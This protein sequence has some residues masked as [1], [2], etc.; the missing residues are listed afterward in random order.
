MAG[1]RV[2]TINRSNYHSTRPQIETAAKVLAGLTGR[3][4]LTRKGFEHNGTVLDAAS[5]DLVRTLMVERNL[6][7]LVIRESMTE[8]QVVEFLT[9]ILF[10]PKKAIS[11]ARG[12]N[13]L[14]NLP[15]RIDSELGLELVRVEDQTLFVAKEEEG[16][17]YTIHQLKDGAV[18][19]LGEETI[20][21]M[22]DNGFTHIFI[23]SGRFSRHA[24]KMHPGGHLIDGELGMQSARTSDWTREVAMIDQEKCKA[25]EQCVIFC[26]EGVIEIIEQQIEGQ[27]K[28]DKTVL[29]TDLLNCK[30]C[31]L[32]FEACPPKTAAIEM[33]NKAS[34]IGQELMRRARQRGEG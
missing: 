16:T 4:S 21:F 31:G 30:G 24:D 20:D 3:V 6:K 26:P 18:R 12:L 7:S 9:E 1:I 33:V 34:E 14:L 10:E 25:C 22:R 19:G 27:K 23:G 28:P 2:T 8:A 29:I 17:L 15:E 11:N 13:L 32:C 5:K